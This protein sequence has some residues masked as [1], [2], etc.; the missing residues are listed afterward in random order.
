LEI[1]TLVWDLFWLKKVSLKLKYL[2]YHGGVG[3]HGG[4]NVGVIVDGGAGVPII[5][6]ALLIGGIIHTGVP[7]SG[8][9]GD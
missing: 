2:I 3:G 5:G 4:I 8:D 9:G 7:G 6:G 1:L